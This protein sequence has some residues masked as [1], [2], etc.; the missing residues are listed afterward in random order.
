[1]FE[2]KLPPEDI[3]EQG[4]KEALALMHILFFT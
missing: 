2:K 1:V 4:A 3:L